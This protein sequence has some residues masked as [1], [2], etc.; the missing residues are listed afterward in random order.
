MGQAEQIVTENIKDFPS[1]ELQRFGIE[2]VTADAFLINAFELYPEITIAT[3]RARAARLRN[4]AI[5][6]HGVL[7]ALRESGAPKFT[8]MLSAALGIDPV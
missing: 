5:G 2:A 7:K 6:I 3:T 1:V 8:A 4:P